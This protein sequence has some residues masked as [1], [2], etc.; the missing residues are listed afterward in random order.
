MQRVQTN[1]RSNRNSQDYTNI[2]TT[3]SNNQNETIRTVQT[4]VQSNTDRQD[5]PNNPTKLIQSIK[6]VERHSPIISQQCGPAECAKRLNK[7]KE[8]SNLVDATH[9]QQNQKKQTS[10]ATRVPRHAPSATQVRNGLVASRASVKVFHF[11][12][13]PVRHS[14]GQINR[15]PKHK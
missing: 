6:T 4:Q 7:H 14:Q 10:P 13:I 2:L 11:R 9:P 8:T 3:D 15:D 5:N 12:N 1:L